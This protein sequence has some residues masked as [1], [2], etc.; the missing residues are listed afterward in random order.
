M[1]QAEVEVEPVYALVDKSLK[2]QV[3]EQ[4]ISNKRKQRGLIYIT[5]VIEDGF[6]KW[7]VAESRK[8]R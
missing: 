7:L 5:E 3:M 2:R 6:R 8:G 1:D 4:C